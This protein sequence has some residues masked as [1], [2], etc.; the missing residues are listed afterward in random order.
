MTTDDDERW[1]AARSHGGTA[2]LNVDEGPLVVCDG[3]DG[4]DR[5]LLHLANPAVEANSDN[6]DASGGGGSRATPWRR[7]WQWRGSGL[8]G[9][10][11]GRLGDALYRLGLERSDSKRE[12]LSRKI[13]GLVWRDKLENEFDSD[14][15]QSN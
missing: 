6:S 5:V 4:V 15:I 2:R 11:R 8:E 14:N 9:K 13:L 7:F 12:D 10:R 3:D 1:L